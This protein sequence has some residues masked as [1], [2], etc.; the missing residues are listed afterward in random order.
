MSLLDS[1]TA[2]GLWLRWLPTF[3]GFIAGGA[4]AIAV[5]GPVTSLATALGGGAVAGAILGAAQWL[6]L[7]GR[8]PK[9]EWWIPATAVGQAVGLAA[10]ATLVGY[11]TSLQDL[12]IQGAITGLGVGVLQALVLR[13]HV[14]AWFWWALAMPPLW[15]LGWIVTTAAGISVDQHFT[16]FGASGAIVVTIL[17]GLLLVVLLRAP[18]RIDAAT[19]PAVAAA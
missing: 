8:L 4:I 13:P 14:A 1:R 12:A 3:V 9:S 18:R 11:R 17:S 19:R 2:Q 7:R 5:L 15:A 10:G 16:N 6:A